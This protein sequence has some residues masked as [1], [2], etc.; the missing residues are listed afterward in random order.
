MKIIYAEVRNFGSY[1]H[2]EFEFQDQGLTL[3][4]G[5]TGA[6]K[7]TL[8]DIIPWTL[9]GVT[10]KNGLADD[11]RAWNSTA[12]TE[13]RMI[14]DDGT[15]R[16]EVTR[17]RGPKSND[18]W[19]KRIG[20]IIEPFNAQIGGHVRGK[21]L[22]DTQ[23]LLNEALG[24]DANLYLSGAYFHEFSQTASFFTANAK[25]RR[26]VTEQLVDV[27]LSKNLSEK[28]TARRKGLK[29]QGD[30]ISGMR[31]DVSTKIKMAQDQHRG[32]TARKAEWQQKQLRRIAAAREAADS[33]EDDRVAEIRL[34]EA[35]D[36]DFEIERDRRIAKHR[37]DLDALKESLSID[38]ISERASVSGWIQQLT[39]TKCEHCG[40]PLHN[41]K[42]MSMMARQHDLDMAIAAQA[43]SRRTQITL[44]NLI[45]RENQEVNPH[46]ER[47]EKARERT[48]TYQDQTLQLLEE[49]NPYL[50][51]AAQ[52]VMQLD[53]ILADHQS[54][55]SLQDDWKEQQADTEL[56]ISILDTF[57]TTLISSAISDLETK[58]NDLLTQHFDA[59]IR[60]LFDAK[61]ADK[62][63]ATITKDGNECSYA[64]LS[65]G[66]RQLLKL[67]FGVAVMRIVSNHNAVNFDAIFL[68]EFADGCD[69]DIKA[70]AF[71]LLQHLALEYGS[72]FAIDHSEGLKSMF[73][74]RYDVELSSGKTKI[75][76]S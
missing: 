18:L 71:G 2:L 57:R 56:L 45:K 70:K 44:E 36:Q 42:I 11:V 46:I 47:L 14:I 24:F 39:D 43:N 16:L 20:S 28:A 38:H 17:V 8:C 41:A 40:G 69:E 3:I 22:A 73:T 75:T 52:A 29:A 10:A 35:A 66:Q 65:K 74:N 4:A 23:R 12:P 37:G 49:E 62:L 60:V 31:R 53:T 58:T 64:Q 7:S 21:D 67:C 33:F 26:V 27:N 32:E 50:K 1:E 19:F 59:E 15:Q 30:E 6:G 5:P 61:D 63:E 34:L 51:S 72:V 76:K 9:F 68:D 48:N 55:L 13:G 54:I 25:V